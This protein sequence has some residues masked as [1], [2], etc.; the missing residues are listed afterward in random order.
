M[1]Q[2]VGIISGQKK[3]AAR[4]TEKYLM[5]VRRDCMYQLNYINRN[6]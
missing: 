3:K 2:N 1:L 6:V 5:K 4:F